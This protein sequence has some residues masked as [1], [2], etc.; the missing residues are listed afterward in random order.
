MINLNEHRWDPKIPIEV[1]VAIAEK[2]EKDFLSHFSEGDEV[3]AISRSEYSTS[4]ENFRVSSISGEEGGRVDRIDRSDS[5]IRIEW[6]NGQTIW[7]DYSDMEDEGVFCHASL[8]GDVRDM[9]QNGR[10]TQEIVS[11]MIVTGKPFNSYV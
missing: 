3:V 4:Y 2:Y 5:D 11:Y 1:L 8:L 7:V 10:S 9:I 6:M